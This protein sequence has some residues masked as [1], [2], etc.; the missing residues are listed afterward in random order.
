MILGDTAKMGIKR[1]EFGPFHQKTATGKTPV[2]DV[3]AVAKIRSSEIKV[4]FNFLSSITFN[5]D[6]NKS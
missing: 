1:P 3:G 4:G 6:T 2:L 5:N